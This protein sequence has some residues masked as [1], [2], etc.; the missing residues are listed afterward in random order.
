MGLGRRTV[1]V[2]GVHL[3]ANTRDGLE[4]GDS[5]LRQGVENMVSSIARSI[6]SYLIIHGLDTNG[7]L[8]GVQLHPCNIRE[9]ALE[10][11][12]FERLARNGV[13]VVV[14]PQTILWTLLTVLPNA[15]RTFAHPLLRLHHLSR[16]SRS[17][18]PS[19]RPHH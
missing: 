3:V 6:D 7:T 5:R 10:L 13:V 12:I 11:R 18:C 2:G 9:I 17:R 8:A 1:E 19:G 15:I 14:L 4:N 16:D